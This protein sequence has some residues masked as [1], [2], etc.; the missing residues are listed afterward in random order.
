MSGMVRG[1]S[2]WEVRARV[3]ASGIYRTKNSL[4]GGMKG[5][6]L[7]VVD[8]LVIVISARNAVCEW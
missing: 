2:A 8:N 7:G 5:I 4:R 3:E 6:V 1:A